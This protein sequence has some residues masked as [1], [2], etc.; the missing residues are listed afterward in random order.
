MKLI[1]TAP[2]DHL[3]IPGEIVEVKDGY[4]RN[5]LLPRNLATPWTKGGQKQV[6]AI[7]K[8]RV[9]RE[10]AT[11]EAA[12]S[13]KATL[14]SGPIRLAAQ[15][16]ASGRLFGAVTTSDIAAAVKGR[17]DADIDRRKVEVGNA[18]KTVGTYTVAVRLHPEVV[19]TVTLDVVPA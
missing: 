15:A 14:E 8:A 11:V 2:V 3:G 4:G 13:L 19:A 16:G 18:I 5:Y 17:H 1:L 12:Q 6:D 10:I 7:R 9:N